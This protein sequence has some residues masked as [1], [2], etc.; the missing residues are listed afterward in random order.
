MVIIKIT[1]Q[2]QNSSGTGSDIILLT[3]KRMPD[4]IIFVQHFEFLLR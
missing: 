3:L 4:L 1:G 2:A